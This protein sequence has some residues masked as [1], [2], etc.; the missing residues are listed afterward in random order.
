MQNEDVYVEL[1][2]ISLKEG[3]TNCKDVSRKLY[4][5][6]VQ[7]TDTK[8][9]KR[10]V[11]R[12]KSV[13]RTKISSGETVRV[14]PRKITLYSTRKPVTVSVRNSPA[15]RKMVL[16]IYLDELVRMSVL[17]IYL[18]AS[19]Q[20]ALHLGSK[21]SKSRFKTTVDLRTVNATSKAE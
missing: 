6:T 4:Q 5:M 19:W 14:P 21:G 17:K 11:D 2:M 12:R 3:K 13:F 9:L 8:D 10:I 20:V 18:E 16:D 7:K 15:G 1:Q